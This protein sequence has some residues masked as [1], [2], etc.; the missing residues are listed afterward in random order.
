MVMRDLALGAAFCLLAL[1][2]A[3]LVQADCPTPASPDRIA[4][5]ILIAH[6]SQGEIDGQG[7]ID[8]ECA[9]LNGRLP[10]AFS[11]LRAKAQRCF[12]L[13]FGE[14]A[15]MALPSG[16]SVQFLPISI[17]DDMLHVQ[18]LMPGVL[19]TRLRTATGR[20][21]IVAAGKDEIGQLFIELTPSFTPPLLLTPGQQKVPKVRQAG[22]HRP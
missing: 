18:L 21:V 7:G 6:G 4:L 22:D 17:V 8:A 13:A 12:N 10:V 9:A 5:S 19:N 15:E 14:S 20:A 2:T 3:G 16:G 1:G 11:T